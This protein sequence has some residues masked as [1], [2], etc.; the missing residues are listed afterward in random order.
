MMTANSMV[1]CISLYSYIKPQLKHYG[2]TGKWA[3]YPYIPTSNRNFQLIDNVLMRAVY[4]YIPTSNRNAFLV[5][6]DI[7]RLYI[8]IFLHQTATPLL[9]YLRVSSCISLY[10]YIKPQPCCSAWATSSAVYPYIP[11]SNRNVRC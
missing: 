7:L 5:I 11:T 10:S 6:D 1:R 2:N 4:P 3:V 8:L 9:A